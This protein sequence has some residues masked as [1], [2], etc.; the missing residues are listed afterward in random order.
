MVSSVELACTQAVLVVYVSSCDG[1][2]AV[3]VGMH[4]G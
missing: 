2:V 1:W 3:L 4:E